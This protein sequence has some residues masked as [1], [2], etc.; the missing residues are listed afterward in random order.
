V[1]LLFNEFLRYNTGNCSKGEAQMSRDPVERVLNHNMEKPESR[2][3]DP[4]FHHVP[5]TKVTEAQRY[6]PNAIFDGK[7]FGQ[8][9]TG[10]GT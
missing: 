5:D 2:V 10:D 6:D 3:Y 1:W 8:P 9:A 4:I 7:N